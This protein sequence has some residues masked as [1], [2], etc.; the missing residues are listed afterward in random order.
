[1]ASFKRLRGFKKSKLFQISAWE[2]SF[3][4]FRM[5]TSQA[6]FLY[7]GRRF[8][9][10]NSISGF[11]SAAPHFIPQILGETR[12]KYL[13]DELEARPASLVGDSSLHCFGMVIHSEGTHSLLFYHVRSEER[14]QCLEVLENSP[15]PVQMFSGNKGNVQSPSSLTPWYYL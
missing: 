11:P 10:S 14:T 1:M 5:E 13:I 2:C 3:L 9:N 15:S 4:F 7:R 6:S 8:Y 12:H